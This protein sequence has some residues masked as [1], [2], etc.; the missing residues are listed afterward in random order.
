MQSTRK[1]TGATGNERRGKGGK[2]MNVY[3]KEIVYTI[4]FFLL[5]LLVAHTAIWAL[6]FKTDNS[7]RVL[8][9][10]FHYFAAIF[11][12]WLGV[13]AVSVWWNRCADALEEEITRDEAESRH[14]GERP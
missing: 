7:L 4:G 3:R 1:T 14:M 12:G 5:Y 9:L 10:P 2:G 11:L 8:G 13:L 6:L